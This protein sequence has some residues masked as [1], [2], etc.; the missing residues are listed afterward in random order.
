MKTIPSQ[1]LQTNVDAVLDSSQSERIVI[2]RQGKPCAVL[3]GIQ[4]YD[5][6]DLQLATS[7]DFWLMIHQRRTEG[8]SV[9]LADV[10][11]Q[12]KT[13]RGKLG[14]QRSAGRKP[15]KPK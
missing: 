3:V 15:R 14:G 6:E 4:D 2:S 8:R 13:R 5:A 7:P 1:E 9:P 10:E 12:L 11:T